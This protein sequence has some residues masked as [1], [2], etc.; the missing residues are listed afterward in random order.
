MYCKILITGTMTTVQQTP[1][2]SKDPPSYY[3]IYLHEQAP[4]TETSTSR[5]H[6]IKRYFRR[7]CA[8]FQRL[9][10]AVFVATTISTTIMLLLWQLQNLTDPSG[11][12]DPWFD[13]DMAL[14]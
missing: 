2:L 7:H 12:D 3:S 4:G 8:F 13:P 10:A 14:S 9:I 5:S 6:S 11:V 1:L